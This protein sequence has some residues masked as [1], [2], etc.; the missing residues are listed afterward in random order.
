MHILE[1]MG[2]KNL[3]FFFPR[4]LA[5]FT[6]IESINFDDFRLSKKKLFLGPLI[7]ILDILDLSFSGLV[8]MI[9]HLLIPENPTVLPQMSQSKMNI[10]CECM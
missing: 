1:L 7:D 9:L 4:G 8:S 2:P 10:A 6:H 3:Y 5:R